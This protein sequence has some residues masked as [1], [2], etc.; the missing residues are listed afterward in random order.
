METP[1]YNPDFHSDTWKFVK[2]NMEACMDLD[3]LL[4]E[5]DQT[6]TQTAKLR[7][8]IEAFRVFL[9]KMEKLST[10]K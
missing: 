7:G 2:Q 5:R 4:L 10:I 3:R 6:E 9:N 1:K 8:R